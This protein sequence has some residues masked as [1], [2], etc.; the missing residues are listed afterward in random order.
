MAKY[1]ITNYYTIAH[2][3][4]QE[5]NAFTDG[6]HSCA[7]RRVNRPWAC[8]AQLM[9]EEHAHAG[10]RK[11]KSLRADLNEVCDQAVIKVLAAQV[12]VARRRLDLLHSKRLSVA[13]LPFGADRSGWIKLTLLDSYCM[14]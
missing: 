1:Q 7:R 11:A 5:N 9:A 8:S 6:R 4:L 12:R 3:T 14:Y 2:N 13:S 10:A